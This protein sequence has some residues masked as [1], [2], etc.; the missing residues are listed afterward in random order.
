LIS[1]ISFFLSG[2]GD[3]FSYGISGSKRYCNDQDS[4][5]GIDDVDVV[6]L[7]TLADKPFLQY[8]NLH[9]TDIRLE[10]PSI[11]ASLVLSGLQFGI[12]AGCHTACQLI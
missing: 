1:R 10:L 8:G 6:I 5:R 9:N 12:V 2:S 3:I 4:G 11:D 7:T